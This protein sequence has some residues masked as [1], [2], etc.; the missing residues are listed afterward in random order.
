MH[1]EINLNQIFWLVSFLVVFTW[2][3]IYPKD[4]FT[5]FLEVAPAIIGFVLIVFTRK[6]FPLTSL[7]YFL[8]LIHCFI[9]MV[10]GHYTYAEVPL[11]DTFKEMF[12]WSRNNYDKVGHFAQGLVPALIAREIL[13]RKQIVKGQAW[14]NFISVSITLA[15][16][17]FYELIE[18]WVAL[19][20]EE[21][22]EAFL[23]TQGYV[24]DTQSDMGYA[25]LGAICAVVFL[26]KIHNRQIKNLS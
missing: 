17:A 19:S 16:S 2:S 24:W 22:A 12:N 11:F 6:R 15:F 10:G 7:L 8:I 20:S 5:W 13:I 14:V 1:K 4:G 26:S 9:L 21:A 18:W 25:L 23:G 3:A